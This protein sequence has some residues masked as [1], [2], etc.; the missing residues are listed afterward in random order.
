MGRGTTQPSSSTV[1]TSSAPPRARGTQAPTGHGATRG[2]AQSSGGLSRFY[3]MS[4]YQSAKASPNVVIGILAVQSNN[5]YALIDPGSTLSYVTP[6]VAMEFGIEPEQVR[7]PFSVSIPVGESIVA[8]RVYKGYVVTVHGWDTVADLIELGMV[9]LD[10]IMGIDW[11]YLCFTKI[12]CRTRTVRLELPNE[13]VV[14]WKGDNVM[15]KGRFISYL[16]DTKM[17]NKGCNYHVVRVMDTDAEVPILESVPVVNEFPEV[18][19]DELPGISPD[20]E[21]DFG[22]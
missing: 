10:V 12:N 8:A 11:L 20:R 6:Y 21:I 9:D 7:E 1:A 2:G 14:E 3:A 5:V 19:L 16:K 18:F 22:I 4:G 13:P 17:I 15:P